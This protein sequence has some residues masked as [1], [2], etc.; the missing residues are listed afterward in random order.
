RGRE[1]FADRGDDTPGNQ[2]ELGA[3][4]HWRISMSDL[5]VSRPALARTLRF[6]LRALARKS[7]ASQ[8]VP[9]NPRPALPRPKSIGT[10]RTVGPAALRGAGRAPDDVFRNNPSPTIASPP[11]WVTPLT[12]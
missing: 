8:N 12:T 3:P 9:T 10:A 7:A 6:H 11:I 2:N 1:A 5:P 4:T